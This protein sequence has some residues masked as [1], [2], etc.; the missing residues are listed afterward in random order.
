MAMNTLPAI[1]LSLSV[2]VI[3][4]TIKDTSVVPVSTKSDNTS[5]S[6][7][8]PIHVVSNAKIKRFFKSFFYKF[9]YLVITFSDKQRI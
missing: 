7:A 3:T 1:Q 2:L 5:S 8:T 9:A 6:S 4:S